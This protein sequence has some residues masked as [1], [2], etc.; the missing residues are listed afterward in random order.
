MVTR[1]SPWSLTGYTSHKPSEFKPLV[2]NRAALYFWPLVFKPLNCSERLPLSWSRHMHGATIKPL[3][4]KPLVWTHIMFDF[5]DSI[6]PLHLSRL[7]GITMWSP[8]LSSDTASAIRPLNFKPLVFQAATNHA[9]SA[10]FEPLHLSRLNGSVAT[11]D[12]ASRLLSR[13]ILSRLIVSGS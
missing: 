4:I 3:E 2:C 1:W 6:K 8:L 11:Q 12:I 5:P 10:L 9:A 7:F 13:L